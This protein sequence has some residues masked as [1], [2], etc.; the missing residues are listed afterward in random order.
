MELVAVDMLLEPAVEVELQVSNK[1]LLKAIHIAS[2]RSSSWTP[3]GNVALNRSLRE[4]T[5]LVNGD[6]RSVSG[7]F[8]G[9][10]GSTPIR[11]RVTVVSARGEHRFSFASSSLSPHGF[12]LREMFLGG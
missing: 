7:K 9:L 4:I 6:S 11:T 5:I 12:I 8:T 10:M 3:H 1:T 2:L